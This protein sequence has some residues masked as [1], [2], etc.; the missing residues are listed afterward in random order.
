RYDQYSVLRTAELML[1]MQPLSLNDALA[2]PM[3][4]AFTTHPDSRPYDA[5]TP[6]HPLNEVN[7]SAAAAPQVQASSS[8]AASERAFALDLPFDKVDLVPQALSD[9]VLWH[10]IY[11][12]NSTPP[13]PGPGASPAE[14]LRAKVAERAHAKHANVA[15]ALEGL[16]GGDTDG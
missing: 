10:S 2:V 16:G 3:Y 6:T 4:D 15:Q 12:W 11:G 14:E 13:S 9:Q 1:G 5:V 7:P 8:T